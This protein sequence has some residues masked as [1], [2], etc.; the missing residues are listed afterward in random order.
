[1]GSTGV[2]VYKA[3]TLIGTV[4]RKREK[5]PKEYSLRGLELSEDPQG[6]LE[7]ST[8]IVVYSTGYIYIH[9]Y[10]LLYTTQK[11]ASDDRV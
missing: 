6:H 8:C 9:I 3:K 11:K 7:A 5:C 4:G 10:L 2:E 1:M